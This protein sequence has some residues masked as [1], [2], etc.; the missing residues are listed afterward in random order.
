MYDEMIENDIIDNLRDIN[1]NGTLLDMLLEFEEILDSHGIYAYKNWEFGE[2]VYGPK[3]SRHWLNVGLMYPYKKMPEPV[4]LRRLAEIGCEI[5]F[6]KSAL[7]VPVTPKSQEDLD[8]EG[9]PKL[10][11]NKVWILDCWIPRKLVDDFDDDKVNVGDEEI[12]MEEL[13][14]AYDSGL[15][16]ESAVE[17]QQEV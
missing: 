3:L 15:D 11:S 7:K 1:K 8:E 5:E 13:N 12:N 6:K 17:Q 14:S 9:Q 10:K 4:A 16:D 2:V